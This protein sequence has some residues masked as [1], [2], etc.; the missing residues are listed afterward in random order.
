M[1]NTTRILQVMATLGFVLAFFEI[2]IGWFIGF[3]FTG[4]FFILLKDD[5][6][7][8]KKTNI[9]FG[10]IILIYSFYALYSQSTFF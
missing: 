8:L 7:K 4:I 1:I 3:F 10:L 9:S 6:K 5:Q 2:G